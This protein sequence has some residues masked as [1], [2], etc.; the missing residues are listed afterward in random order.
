MTPPKVSVG[1]WSRDIAKILH[2][3][4][5]GRPRRRG[6]EA[7][8]EQR[9]GWVLRARSAHDDGSGMGLA[10]IKSLPP[11]LVHRLE[12]LDDALAN[13]YTAAAHPLPEH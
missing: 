13:R 3:M 5:K 6:L 11:A 1:A 9:S 8:G 2:T 4:E 10:S 12:T 7:R